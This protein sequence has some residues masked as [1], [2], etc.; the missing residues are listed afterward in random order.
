MSLEL[1]GT[2]VIGT[3]TLRLP[4]GASALQVVT[5][6]GQALTVRPTG[7]A[8]VL[9]P[10]TAQ[11]PT[12]TNKVTVVPGAPVTIGAVP[13][14]LGLGGTLVVGGKTQ[15]I[16]ATGS[17]IF[18]ISGQ[19]I[20]I[21]SGGF[22]AV[23]PTPTTARLTT[24]AT[25]T[26]SF[27]F[28]TSFISIPGLTTWSKTT[29]EL[30]GSTASTILPIWPCQTLCAS[31]YNGVIIILKSLLLPSTLVILP[32]FGFPSLTIAPDS[33]P[34]VVPTVPPSISATIPTTIHPT[35]IVD[36]ISS[37]MTTIPPEFSTEEAT[38]TLWTAN[39]WITTTVA[40]QT[41][42]VPVLVGCNGCG[43]VHGGIILWNLPKLPWVS[44]QFPGFPGLPKF[45][46]PCIKIFGITISGNCDSP[47]STEGDNSNDPTT[48]SN[49]TSRKDTSVR[50]TTSFS[51][52]S[53]SQ[54]C[55]STAV[56][57]CTQLCESITHSGGAVTKSWASAVCQTITACSMTPTTKTTYSSTKT[58][59]QICEPSCAACG[60][61]SS[62]SGVS[63]SS[64]Q[65]GLAKRIMPQ[66][67]SLD[68]HFTWFVGMAV[69]SYQLPSDSNGPIGLSSSD[70]M[71]PWPPGEP[72]HAGASAF[73]IG[74]T[75]LHGCAVV[76]V[77]T[78]Q[79]LWMAHIWEGSFSDE[80]FDADVLEFIATGA[81]ARGRE[82][83]NPYAVTGYTSTGERINF[84]LDPRQRPLVMIIAA[85][86]RDALWLDAPAKSNKFERLRDALQVRFPYSTIQENNYIT[87]I[88]G[89]YLNETSQYGK[90]LVQYDPAQP[91][92]H[93]VLYP[94]FRVWVQ[95][96]VASITA[97]AGYPLQPRGVAGK[98]ATFNSLCPLSW[99]Q[100]VTPY[101]TTTTSYTGPNTD[102]TTLLSTSTSRN[103]TQQASST[104]PT[105]HTIASATL[106]SHTT[107]SKVPTNTSPVA[108]NQPVLCIPL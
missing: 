29:M 56:A 12:A 23:L 95:G 83:L 20:T 11:L 67:T 42:V 107:T 75:G 100:S 7:F 16:P 61:R 93:G 97:F 15:I 43:G 80:K 87:S 108:I 27:V 59:Y 50:S 33:Q 57:S 35:A 68:S 91:D 13:V 41:I 39:T 54:S 2:L 86:D 98:L 10:P 53:P 48:T 104:T 47:P 32:P 70:I 24:L 74:V 51:S 101:D 105:S 92:C 60:S 17:E 1:S 99:G 5:I 26:K 73:E 79:A 49:P 55:H 82:G 63:P 40:G 84:E 30:I 21:S 45:Y 22:V 46:L 71:L 89:E 81:P 58:S 78:P 96:N 4:T 103:S 66:P 94:S 76:I 102:P 85:R 25:G 106:M 72:G 36:S 19:L 62:T 77:A 44:F 28:M 37:T 88:L 8:I 9:Q 65:S 34:T 38:N 18:T 3:N 69:N 6:G 14:S 64:K 90:V 31:G 52:S